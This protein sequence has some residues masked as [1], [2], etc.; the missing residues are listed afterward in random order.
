MQ[1]MTIL[2]VVAVTTGVI[3]FVAAIVCGVA[4][5]GL[6]GAANGLRLFFRRENGVW[7]T[8]LVACIVATGLCLTHPGESLIVARESSGHQLF[9]HQ[10]APMEVVTDHSSA[11]LPPVV[12]S[13]SGFVPRTWKWYPVTFVM[14]VLLVPFFFYAYGDEIEEATHNAAQR[15]R[16]RGSHVATRGGAAG[17]IQ[18]VIGGGGEGSGDTGSGGRG[19]TFGNLLG[20]EI[21]GEIISEIFAKLVLQMRG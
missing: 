2:L 8:C 11:Y 20:A 16:V 6:V 21:V 4:V 13:A 18:R 12:K 17:V 15:I 3:M 14:W 10:L 1:V 5:N 9:A 7:V 19:I